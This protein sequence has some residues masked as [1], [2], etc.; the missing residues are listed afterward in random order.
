MVES[1]LLTREADFRVLLGTVLSADQLATYE[2]LASAHD[3]DARTLN[4]HPSH[5]HNDMSK[6]SPTLVEPSDDAPKP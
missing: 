2:S 5:G 1:G 6:P 4:P 3:A